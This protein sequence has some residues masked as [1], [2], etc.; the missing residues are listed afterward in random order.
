VQGL[1]AAKAC[2]QAGCESV[3]VPAAALLALGPDTVVPR[4]VVASLPR[5]MHDAEAGKLLAAVEGASRAQAATLGALAVCAER[6]ITAEAHWSLNAANA[7]SVAELAEMG[8]SFAWLSPELSSRQVAEVCSASVLP[9]GIAV[10][11]RQELMVT[12]HC[13]LMAK[14]PCSQRCETC[15]RRKG[16]HFLRDRKGY[17]F[18]VHTDGSGRSHVYNSVPLDLTHALPEVIATGVSALRLDLETE[19]P[20]RA[21]AEV[22]RVRQALQDTLAGREPERVDRERVT[23]GHF[24]RG[25]S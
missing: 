7:Y 11:G 13:I 12:E 22:A 1:P 3:Y 20:N 15:P 21:A 4:G 24:F 23:S 25:V 14:G 5:V 19:T 16:W 18:P 9:V 17:S 8:A 10:S 6:G 2:L